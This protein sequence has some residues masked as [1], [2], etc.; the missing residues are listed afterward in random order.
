MATTFTSIARALAL[1]GTATVMSLSPAQAQAQA[2]DGKSFDGIF[3]AK[4]KKSGDPDT[5]SFKDG[6][7]HSSACDQYGYSI[8]PYQTTV[9]G[10]AVRFEAET[11]SPKY[12]KLRW[13]G[14][15]RGD[16]LDATVM[17]IQAGKAP[18]EHWVAASLK[19]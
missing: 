16:K 5:V 14:Y 7:I 17:M 13:T 11:E 9:D 10:N 4:G 2:L 1:A 15:V 19:K 18:V 3:I 6:R 8:A 12:G